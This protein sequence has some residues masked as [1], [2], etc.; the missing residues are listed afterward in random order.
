M[1]KHCRE[2]DFLKN[3]LPYPG[4]ITALL[5]SQNHFPQA[6]D[7]TEKIRI[8][9]PDS[10]LIGESQ[11]NILNPDGPSGKALKKHY[12]DTHQ[13]SLAKTKYY[14]SMLERER[15]IQEQLVDLMDLG[16]SDDDFPEQVL[17]EFGDA[18]ELDP[19]DVADEDDAAGPSHS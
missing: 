8:L 2:G 16:D 7:T 15:R 10:R 12:K 3:N 18:V 9:N 19:D 14:L 11:T 6:S 4:L 1:K 5:V 13:K 17:D